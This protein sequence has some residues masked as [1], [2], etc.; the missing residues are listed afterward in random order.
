VGEYNPS[1]DTFLYESVQKEI[2]GIGAALGNGQ[3]SKIWIS[4]AGKPDKT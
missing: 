3:L 1:G 2:Q 4:L